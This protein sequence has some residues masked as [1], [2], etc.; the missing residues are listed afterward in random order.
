MSKTSQA[1][2]PVG[3]TILEWLNEFPEPYRSQALANAA[4]AD[5]LC[6]K[7]DTQADAISM[8]FDWNSSPEGGKYWSWLCGRL[9]TGET[10]DLPSLVRTYLTA[11]DELTDAIMSRDDD[12]RRIGED[13]DKA[14][15][16]LREA[17]GL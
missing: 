11:K 8:A 12:T 3:K 5:L 17:V 6:V 16:A 1:P 13:M 14:E 4:K 9:K 15:K 2:A 10:V 7:A